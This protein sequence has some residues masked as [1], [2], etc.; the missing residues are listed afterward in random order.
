MSSI[1]RLPNRMLPALTSMI[2]S[3]VTTFS[4]IAAGRGDELERRSGFVEILDGA[5]CGGRSPAH[6]VIVR[7]ERR[8]ARH[9]EDLA[10]VRIHDHGGA[11]VG[12][13]RLDTGANLALRDVLQGARRWSARS[14]RRRSAIARA[15]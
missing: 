2:W 12:A 14:M 3:G 5:V 9:R 7:I 6:R 4:S 10:G 11:A 13:R 8:P 15:G 1:T